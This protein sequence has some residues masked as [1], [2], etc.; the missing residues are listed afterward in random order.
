MKKCPCGS[1]LD[2]S[3]CCNLYLSH[4]E[5]PKTPEALMRSRYTAFT[6]SNTSYIKD[7]M[8]GKALLGFNELETFNWSKSVVWLGLKVVFSSLEDKNAGSV[9]FIAKFLESDSIKF[10]H[11]KSQFER[12]DNKWFY[13]GGK[14]IPEPSL[15]IARNTTCPCGS[16][17]KFKN[18]HEFS[19][20]QSNL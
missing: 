17:K 4:K 1:N 18:C 9:E 20:N 14:H 15:K 12:I 16:K 3:S 10:I 6:L 11:E 7:T 2:F 5:L 8:K 13:S 19:I